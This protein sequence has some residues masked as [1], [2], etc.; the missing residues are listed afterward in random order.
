[1][2]P[3]KYWELN[4]DDDLAALRRRREADARGDPRI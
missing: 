1:M 4:I 2:E 3:A